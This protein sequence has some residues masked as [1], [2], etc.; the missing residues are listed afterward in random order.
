[1][2]ICVDCIFL[3]ESSELRNMIQMLL[4]NEILI[5]VMPDIA[6]LPVQK[7]SANR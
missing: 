6:Q 3:V 4:K 5:F 2:Y 1:M 7:V